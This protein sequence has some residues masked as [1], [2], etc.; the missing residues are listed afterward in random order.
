MSGV[1][2]ITV[3]L[4]AH[5]PEALS[6]AAKLM[7]EHDAV[8]LEEPDTPG[9]RRMLDGTLSI[10]DYLRATDFEFPELSRRACR[11]YRQLH[12]SGKVLF[13]IDP[14][15][16]LL[17]GI[18]AL[19]ESGG[20]PGEIDPATEQGQVYA[21]ERTWTAALLAYYERSLSAP[22]DEV[23]TTVK[24]FAREDAARGRFR[25][26][27]RARAISAVVAPFRRVYVEAG[28]LHVYLLNRLAAELPQW[29]LRPVFLLA[30][31]LQRLCGKRQAFGPGDK[32]T[33]SYTYRPDYCGPRAD[34]LA[35]RSLVHIKILHKEEL[36]ASR[37]AYP[38]CRDEVECNAY[39]ESLN[40]ADCA[41]L[42]QRIKR[43]PTTEAKAIVRD[44]IRTREH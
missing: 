31:V 25:D 16:T 28:S 30:P 17:S 3:A 8:L 2:H 12:Q 13:Q 18:H 4:S 33:L 27:L 20:K 22:F 38:H 36:V 39:V 44:Y 5:R 24:A 15:M 19:F 14:Y 40:Y 21:R 29:K 6:A 11:I 32:L 34:I 1:K 43:R 37:G 42:Y 41:A 35:A 7:A 9:F 23:V 26:A 10:G